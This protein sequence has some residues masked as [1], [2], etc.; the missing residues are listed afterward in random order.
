MFAKFANLSSVNRMP[1]LKSGGTT[2]TAG[3]VASGSSGK[4][5]LTLARSGIVV[6]TGFILLATFLYAK[7][8]AVGPPSKVVPRMKSLRITTISE[9]SSNNALSSTFAATLTATSRNGVQYSSGID[10]TLIVAAVALTVTMVPFSSPA[11]CFSNSFAFPLVIANASASLS[12]S[13]TSINAISSS[14]SPLH[15]LS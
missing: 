2:G 5:H 8:C 12:S 7:V 4:W 15:S 10:W 1:G 6:E 14:S 11:F 3:S 9:P 13:K